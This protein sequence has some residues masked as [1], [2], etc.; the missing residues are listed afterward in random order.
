MV[1]G[2]FS[3]LNLYACTC[4]LVYIFGEKDDNNIFKTEN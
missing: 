3:V 1:I 4:I 2:Y